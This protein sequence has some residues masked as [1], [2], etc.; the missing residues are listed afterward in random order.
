MTV[1]H[2]DPSSGK[3]LFAATFPLSSV[4][5]LGLALLAAAAV[6]IPPFLT[7]YYV[8]TLVLFVIS[9]IALMGYRA[10]TTMG[11]WSFAHAAVMGLGAYAMA[12]LTTPPFAWSFWPMLVLSP[13]VAGLF[14][15]IIAIPVLRTRSF[16]FFLST[17]AAGEALR[18]S[19]IQ[20]SG[21]TGG[22]NGIAFIPRPGTIFGISFASNLT[23]YY[24][25]LAVAMVVAIALTLLYRT[26]F[27]HSVKLV[28]HNEDL[29]KSLGINTLGYRVAA[30]ALG[31]AVAGLAGCLFAGFNG[32]ISPADFDTQ[33][34]FKFITAA[35]VGGVSTLWG[36]VLGLLFLT[37]IE[38]G[39][40]DIPEWVPLLW[41][42]SVIATLLFLP[43]GLESLF[44]AKLRRKGGK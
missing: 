29:S 19:F 43:R 26:D 11:G 32:I 22:N 39:F 23:Y 30:F 31:S 16:Y 1:Q 37:L 41:G 33:M 10:I 38:E 4:Q 24:L 17:F 13:L 20:F 18:Q 42:I 14:A 25:A 34:M 36:P 44:I 2:D 35:I 12:I 21:I 7:G 15:L 5:S 6:A 9:A 3:A 8:N 40:R 28:A 27:G